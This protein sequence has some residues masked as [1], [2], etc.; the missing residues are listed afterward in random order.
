MVAASDETCPDSSPSRETGSKYYADLSMVHREILDRM[1]RGLTIDVNA[2][3]LELTR[4]AVEL[5]IKRSLRKLHARNRKEL[6]SRIAL[7]H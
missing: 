2:K 1:R 3:E 5:H 4:E 7:W 6:L